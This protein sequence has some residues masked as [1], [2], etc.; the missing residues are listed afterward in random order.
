MNINSKTQTKLDE[1]LGVSYE[2]LLATSVA[3]QDEIRS[4]FTRYGALSL[5]GR[6]Q[7]KTAEL[8]GGALR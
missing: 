2:L 6:L 5:L 4:L 1:L 8:S 3:Q 7:G